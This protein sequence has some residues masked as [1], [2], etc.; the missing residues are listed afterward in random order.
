[1]IPQDIMA[2][3]RE[4]GTEYAEPLRRELSEREDVFITTKI[5]PYGF[6]DYDAAIDECIEALGL[7]YIDLLLIHQ[8]GTDEKELYA[9]IER[10]VENGKVRSLG[11][12]NYYTQEDF[13]RITENATIMPA[14]IQNE[15]HIFYK[16][17]SSR[18]M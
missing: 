1:M 13:E 10:A 3:H 15:N 2:T 16:I 4:L 14:V 6:N 11:I 17:Q 7:D 12:S 9:A 18:I 8:Q 5:V